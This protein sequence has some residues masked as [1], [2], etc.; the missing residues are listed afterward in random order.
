MTLSV[1]QA[2]GNVTICLSDKFDFM[3]ADNFRQA[4]ESNEGENYIVDFKSTEYMDSSGLGMLLNM[5]RSIGAKDISLINCKPQI[6]K[7]LVISR[8]EEHF[9]IQ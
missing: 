2:D 8:F 9:S 6:K 4:Y 7:V 5:K 3:S 1:Q